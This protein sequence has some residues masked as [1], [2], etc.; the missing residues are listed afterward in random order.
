MALIRE[1]GVIFPFKTSGMLVISLA[2]VSYLAFTGHC[3]LTLRW[4]HLHTLSGASLN[5]SEWLTFFAN[6][7]LYY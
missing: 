7:H 5:L 6:A 1:V 4:C 2:F 3:L